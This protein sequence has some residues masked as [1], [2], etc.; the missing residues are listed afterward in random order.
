MAMYAGSGRPTA[1]LRL[2][3]TWPYGKTVI[4]ILAISLLY[5]FHSLLLGIDARTYIY[6]LVHVLDIRKN[7]SLVGVRRNA[8]N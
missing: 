6:E 2:S 3:Y 7:H 8:L 4:T 5:N 1:R